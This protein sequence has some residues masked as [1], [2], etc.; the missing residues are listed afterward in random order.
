MS[1][2]SC[3]RMASIVIPAHDEERTI[4]RLLDALADPSSSQLFEIIVVCNGCTDRTADIAREHSPA[5]QVI[6]IDQPSKKLALRTGDLHAGFFPRVFIDADVE[7]ASSD[8][9]RLVQCL[10]PEG[11]LASAPT[12]LI[13]R[14][15]VSWLV[16]S[17][18]DVWERLPQV[19]GGLFGRGVIA[20]SE[21]GNERVQ[22]LPQVMSDDLAMSEAFSADERR[23]VP[24]AV[25]VV[26]PPKKLRD[27]VRRRIRVA[28]GNAEADSAGLRSDSSRTSAGT[29]WRIV[30]DEPLIMIRMPFFVGI[31]MISRWA[32]RRAIKSGDFTTWRRDESSRD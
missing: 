6:E 19:R 5:V 26:R 25:V 18:Y 4:L 28:T 1:A 7:I 3:D 23:V 20:L 9:E 22:Q 2:G 17:Y 30:A 11:I 13:P 24:D 32:A 29:L 31:T 8:V 21:R 10:A 16:R 15:G 14:D 27:L 12:R